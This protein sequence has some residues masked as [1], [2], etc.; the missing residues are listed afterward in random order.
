[1]EGAM[2]RLL[3]SV[4]W[5]HVGEVSASGAKVWNSGENVSVGEGGTV[6]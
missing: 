1:M 2:Q 6:E 3:A 5:A 4:D